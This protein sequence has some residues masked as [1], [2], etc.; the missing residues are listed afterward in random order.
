MKK[1]VLFIVSLIVFF[2]IS[3]GMAWFF[4]KDREKKNN[5]FVEEKMKGLENILN[6][7]STKE[8]NFSEGGIA[9]IITKSMPV[10]EIYKGEKITEI[11]ND[12]FIKKI[13][14]EIVMEYKKK[15]EEWEA[16][17]KKNPMDVDA[18]ISIGM[19]KKF[20]NNYAGARDAWEYAKYLNDGNSVVYYNLGNLYGSY[21][22]DYKKA[23]E[24]FLKAIELED[25]NVNYYIGVADFYRNFYTEKKEKIKIILEE[26]IKQV[27]ND[28]SILAYAGGYYKEEGNKE[29]ALELYKKILSLNPENEEVKEEIKKLEG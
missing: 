8:E 5:L 28:V 14:E 29:R 7:T 17:L 24:N 21:L 4:Y 12:K 11:G 9:D 13:P 26:G 16:V 22:K 3:V 6:T 10:V 23:E 27:P 19:I 25:K 15:L 20:F 18:W 1:T 2:T